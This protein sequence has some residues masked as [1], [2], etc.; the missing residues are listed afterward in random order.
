MKKQEATVLQIVDLIGLDVS[1]ND[2][3]NHLREENESL[4][5]VLFEMYY[6]RALENI[7]GNISIDRTYQ[8]KKYIEIYESLYEGLQ[9][10][11]VSLYKQLS[12]MMDGSGNMKRGVKDS[13]FNKA[14]KQVI[15]EI[16]LCVKTLQDKEDLVGV[17]NKEAKNFWNGA[18]KKEKEFQD[19]YDISKL[20][21]EERDKILDLFKSV[22]S[23]SISSLADIESLNT[24]ADKIAAVE[25]AEELSS[26]VEEKENKYKDVIN[27][28]YVGE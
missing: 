28:E 5:Y 12:V 9:K 17:H 8:L 1:R 6:D 4:S 3:Y 14:M 26:Q 27:T 22:S 11:V 24:D 18:M 10:K 19:I 21:E 20:T 23:L 2:I 25:E 16:D 7:R 13:V 15:S